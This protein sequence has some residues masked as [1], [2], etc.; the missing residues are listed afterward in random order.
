MKIAVV[1]PTAPPHGAGGVTSSHYQLYRLLRERGLDATL[2]TFDERER[3]IPDPEIL[4]FGASRRERSLL[5]LCSALYLKSQGSKRLAYHLADILC[6]VPGVLRMNRAL[7][8]LG[9]DR[10]IIPD[11]CA[12]GLFLDQGHARVTMVAHHNPARFMATPLIG[13]FCPID[14]QRAVALEQ[15]VLRKVDG[16]VAPSAYMERVFRET[17]RFDGPVTTIHNPLDAAFVER[18]PARDPR[19]E[20]GLPAHAPVVYIPSAG[21]VLKGARFV[22]DIVGR[23]GRGCP[24]AIGF[25]LSGAIPPELSRELLALPDNVRILAPGHVDN[26]VNVAY[27][28]SCSFGISPTLIENFSMAILEAV[29]CGLPMAVFA[30]GGNAEIVSDGVNGFC[31]PCPDVAALTDA[32][33]R[34]LDPATCQEMGHNALRM[35]RERFSAAAVVDRYLDFCGCQAPPAARS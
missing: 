8:R 26:E 12:P 1:A 4:R 35:A 25:Y 5:A 18:V 34:L 23:V 21:S 7:R 33:A 30:V 29:F 14:V 10:I 19:P 22:A 9:P 32:A 31:V 20:M 27:L 17:F 16:V 11:H 24:G 2:L 6:A 3:H 28:K 13:D 15:R